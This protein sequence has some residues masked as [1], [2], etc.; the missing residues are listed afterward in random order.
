[1]ALLVSTVDVV[2][3]YEVVLGTT[4]LPDAELELSTVFTAELELAMEVA[5]EEEVLVSTVE[6]VETNPLPE[7][8]LEIRPVIVAELELSMTFEV[9]DAE[10]DEKRLLD[11]VP[12]DAVEVATPEEM[13]EFPKYGALGSRE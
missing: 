1:M 13:E 6:V 10:R 8:E 2:E 3:P 11:K 12:L 4:P 9:E 5:V 7:G